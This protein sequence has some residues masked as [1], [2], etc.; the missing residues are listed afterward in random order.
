MTM[1]EDAGHIDLE[2][3]AQGKHRQLLFKAIFRR[4]AFCVL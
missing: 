3:E 4:I 2:V 1:T